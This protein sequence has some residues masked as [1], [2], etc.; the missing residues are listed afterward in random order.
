MGVHREHHLESV[1]RMEVLAGP[2]G[3]RRWSDAMKGRIIAESL[4]PGVTVRSVAERYGLKP[5]HLTSWRGLARAGKL[6]VPALAGASFATVVVTDLLPP[7]PVQDRIELV[8]GDSAASGLVIFPSNRVRIMVA[9]KPIARHWA[10][11]NGAHGSLRKGHDGLAALVKNELHKDPFTGTV[12][13]FRSRRADR[14]KLL[15]W[16]GTGLVMAYKRLEEH[17]F[18]WPAI[19][20]GVMNLGHAQFEALFSGLDWRRVRAVEARAPT[21]VE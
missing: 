16:D 10:R 14:L 3:Q 15:Y 13:V 17:T 19:K 5:N 20:D 12:F 11:T 18:T 8:V 1:S 6:V 2:T 9:T 4:V 21:A 7:P